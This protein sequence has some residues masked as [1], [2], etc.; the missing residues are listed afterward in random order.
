[1]HEDSLRHFGPISGI[2]AH[3]NLIA[4]AGY[5]NRII[6]W[7]A[8]RREPLAQAHHD[9]LVN[10]CAFS[11]DGRWL[12][13][14]SS[15]Y[16]ARIWE[17][18]SMRLR[19]VLPDH[20]DDVDM[21]LF[22]PADDRIATCAL[23]RCVRVFDRQ[24]QCLKIMRGHTGNVLSLAWSRDGRHVV[25]SSVDGTLRKWD[26]ESGAAEITELGVR[27]D[28]VE[29]GPEGWIFAG[30]DKG[31]IA[32]LADGKTHFVSAHQA[33]VKKIVLDPVQRILVS[34]SYDRTLAVW[35]ILGPGGLEETARTVLPDAGWARAAVVLSDGRVAIGTFGSTYAVFDP[36]A[37]TWDVSGVAAGEAINAVLNVNGR[38]YSVGDA[39]TVRADGARVAETGSLCN[40]LVAAKGQ[41][42]TGGHLG[43]L[44]DAKTGAT[45]YEHHSPLNCAVAFEKDGAEHIAVG[46]Y[47]GEILVFAC[48]SDGALERRH[49][50][51]PY[52]NAVK[53]LA[54]RDGILFSVCASTDLAWHRIQDWTLVKRVSKAHERIANAGCALGRDRFAS[55]GRDRALRLWGPAGAEV[56]P[57]PHPN[58]VKCIGANDD[59]TALLTGSYG[60]TL[61]LFDVVH[62]RWLP[63]RRPTVSGIS[64][65]TWDG[66]RRRFLAAS[67]DGGIY[68]VAA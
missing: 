9:H 10:Q 50:L 68:P 12:V 45:L 5:D 57:S 67:Y 19:M 13:S 34:L 6:L 2:A 25:S 37:S 63:M 16:S 59:G 43:K 56:F 22:S 60:G 61:A 27:T 54:C 17:V 35:R 4:T 62:S 11:S 36:R 33:G 47:T 42:F 58:S 32:I 49:V 23:D 15:D 3:G 52:E 48:G 20:G 46:S 51:Q 64:S 39:G 14:A 66:A 31:R 29:F 28:S 7:D 18:P 41:V 21:A 55:V 1:M 53:G 26:T 40:F 30:D 24:G 8:R 44:F 38:I 65:I